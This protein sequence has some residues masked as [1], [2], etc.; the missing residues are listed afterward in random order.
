MFSDSKKGDKMMLQMIK[1]Y[2]TERVLNGRCNRGMLLEHMLYLAVCCTVGG[3]YYTN[4]LTQ[5]SFM[6]I[7]L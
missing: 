1:L 2:V 5:I 4:F 3:L 7:I 6:M